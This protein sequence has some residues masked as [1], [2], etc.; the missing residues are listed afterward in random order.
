MC[1][2]YCV[3]LFFTKTDVVRLDRCHRFIITMFTILLNFMMND[4]I[5]ILYP[6]MILFFTATKL[7][8]W[9]DLI[10]GFGQCS[11]SA[12]NWNTKPAKRWYAATWPAV[13]R[14]IGSFS[15]NWVMSKQISPVYAVAHH[16]SCDPKQLNAKICPPVEQSVP[17]EYSVSAHTG[18][19]RNQEVNNYSGRS[20]SFLKMFSW[21]M[22]NC[23]N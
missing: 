10:A 20:F 3:C 5:T 19:M 21:Q 4:D 1:A 13:H 7:Q 22:E 15:P 18:H 12:L 2:L 16:W 9:C 6:V 17:I 8:E 23:F 11:V 14:Q